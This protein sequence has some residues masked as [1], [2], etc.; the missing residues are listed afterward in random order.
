[1]PPAVGYYFSTTNVTL[2]TTITKFIYLYVCVAQPLHSVLYAALYFYFWRLAADHKA[3]L[4]PL[5]AA[6]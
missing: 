2:R 3:P 1:M 5:P 6:E 4:P